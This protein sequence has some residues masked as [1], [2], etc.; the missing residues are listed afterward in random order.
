MNPEHSHQETEIAS[1]GET[2]IASSLPD[3]IGMY[4]IPGYGAISLK[5]YLR[6]TKDIEQELPLILAQNK[7]NKEKKD[8]SFDRWKNQIEQTPVNE[9]AGLIQQGLDNPDPAV[10]LACTAMIGWAPGNEQAGLQ[11]KVLEIIRRGLDNPDPAVQRVCADMIGRA[12][13]N[14][15]A[16]LIRQGLDNPDPA[17]Q[18]AC[19]AMIWQAPENERAALVNVLKEKGLD[20]LLIRPSLYKGLKMA[21]E[22]FQRV[23]FSKTGSETTLLRGK[24]EYKVIVRQLTPEAFLPWQKLY[25]D[26]QLW[27][28][29]DFDYVPIEPI[30]SFRLNRRTGLVNVYTGVLDL[31]LDDW[32]KISNDFIPELDQDR[33]TIL[34]TLNEMHI[35]HGHA[36]DANFCLRFDREQGNPVLSK[37]PRIYLI[38][39]DQAVSP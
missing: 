8:K 27:H 4:V 19:V 28:N 9:R 29:N 12:P 13:A 38:D 1:S 11:V 3:D 37:K 15:R 25:D 21:P 22:R 20:I 36:H 34:K 30:F 17:V 31:N 23:K 5:S 6:Y 7:E 18:L 16:G 39:F 10:Q 2:E 26:H 14:E 24:L 32:K 35:S 33:D